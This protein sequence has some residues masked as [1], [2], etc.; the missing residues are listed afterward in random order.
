[1][2]LGNFDLTQVV[3]PVPRGPNR[4]KLLSFGGSINLEYI[5]PFYIY[6]WSCQGNFV[7]EKTRGSFFYRV[8]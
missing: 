1:M 5:L 2:A 6:F 4:K 8:Y 3:F 7:W